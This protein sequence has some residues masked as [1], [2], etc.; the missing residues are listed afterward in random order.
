MCA[1]LF[2]VLLVSGKEFNSVRLLFGLRR[3]VGYFYVSKLVYFNSTTRQK[4]AHYFHD[5]AITIIEGIYI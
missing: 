5:A 2:F 1:N 3:T 4:M